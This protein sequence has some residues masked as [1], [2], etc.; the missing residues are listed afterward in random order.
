MFAIHFSLVN[1]RRPERELVYDWEFECFLVWFS[2][3]AKRI[4]TPLQKTKSY[5]TMFSRSTVSVEPTPEPDV[6]SSKVP[7]FICSFHSFYCFLILLFAQFWFL[8][9]MLHKLMSFS[10]WLAWAFSDYGASAWI[11]SILNIFHCIFFVAASSRIMHH[12]GTLRLCVTLSYGNRE[13]VETLYLPVFSITWD[14]KAFYG[15]DKITCKT[16]RVIFIGC[17][18]NFSLKRL[19]SLNKR[20]NIWYKVGI[21]VAICSTEF[22]LLMV[23][24]SCG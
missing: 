10:S 12:S 6:S 7:V 13:L 8:G 17:H 11:L 19:S 2:E 18:L 15:L 1:A 4:S 20:W 16:L 24:L 23:A 21:R 9:A 22:I 14:V 3:N 5:I